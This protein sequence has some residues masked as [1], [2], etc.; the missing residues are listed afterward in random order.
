MEDL[1][2]LIFFLVIVA[3]NGLKFLIER[4]AK[5]RVA[6]PSNQPKEDPPR[7]TQ[8]SIE[9]FFENIVEQLAPKPREVPDWP[10]N[11]E[12]PDYIQEM[13][14]FGDDQ[15]EELGEVRGQRMTQCL[16]EGLPVFGC[17]PNPRVVALDLNPAD[18]AS[19]PGPVA[20]RVISAV[21]I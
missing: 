16:G 7:N 3:V 14:E 8:P 12:R 2:P 6:T 18:E 13:T 5:K 15:A 11:V 17:V 20:S 19:I 4:G 9:N 1:V 21:E 10:E